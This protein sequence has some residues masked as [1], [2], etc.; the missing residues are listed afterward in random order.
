M[1]FDPSSGVDTFRLTLFLTPPHS[2][3]YLPGRSAS[4]LF[5]DP[6]YPMSSEIYQFLLAQGFRRSGTQVYR[7]YCGSCQECIPIRLSVS[8]FK[9]GRSFRRIL[10]KNQDLTMESVAPLFSEERFTLYQ[11]YIKDRHDDGPM[12]NPEPDDFTSFL[13]CTW[14]QARFVEFRLEGRLV[15]VAA[16]D[17]QSLSLSAVYTFFDPQLSPRSLGTFAILWEIEE[18][19]R[20]GKEWLYL[21]YWI[22]NCQKMAYKSRFKPLQAYRKKQWVWL[23]NSP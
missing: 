14:G 18:A 23:A 11:D 16:V 3:G 2:C 17:H 6:M 12:A 9:P 8:D 4:T 7:P 13:G 20:L 10:K 1:N 21:G 22:P 15:M 19:R 5:V